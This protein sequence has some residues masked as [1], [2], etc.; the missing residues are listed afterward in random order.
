M[1]LKQH[2]TYVWHMSPFD[3][4]YAI[5]YHTI[6]GNK[7]TD[8]RNCIILVTNRRVKLLQTLQSSCILTNVTS[9]QCCTK[10]AE[11][12]STAFDYYVLW[13]RTAL[14]WSLCAVNNDFY[15]VCD[16]MCLCHCKCKTVLSRLSEY[17]RDELTS[18][19]VPYMSV[20]LRSRTRRAGQPAHKPRTSSPT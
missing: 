11:I 9:F 20:S 4:C 13:R 10:S 5:I 17:I 2:I 1:S 14:F 3:Q 6:Q 8:S 16:S 18:V 15:N 19:F 7:L 12:I